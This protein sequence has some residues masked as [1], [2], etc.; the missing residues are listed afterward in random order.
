ME[1][2]RRDEDS[3]LAFISLLIRRYREAPELG[4]GELEVLD[5]PERSVLAHL[6]RLDDDATARGAQPRGRARAPCDAADAGTSPRA[7]CCVDQLCDGTIALDERGRAELAVEGYGY[8]WFRVSPPGD[9][10]LA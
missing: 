3:L 9:R 5:Q 7:R 1:A 4:W 10:R 2:Q 8:H 6:V